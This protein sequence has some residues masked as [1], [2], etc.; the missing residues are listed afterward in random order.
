[1][2]QHVRKDAFR[3]HPNLSEKR[4]DKDEDQDE[5]F[6][7]IIKFNHLLNHIRSNHGIFIDEDHMK[8]AF[9]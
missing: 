3:Q 5:D 2:I 1:M 4:S 8:I 9:L 7:L 6:Y